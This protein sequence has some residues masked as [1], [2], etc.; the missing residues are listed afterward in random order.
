MKEEYYYGIYYF[1]ALC[2]NINSIICTQTNSGR[3]SD[4]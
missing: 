2:D 3:S 1:A 4:T